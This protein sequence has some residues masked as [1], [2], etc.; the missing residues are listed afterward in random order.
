MHSWKTVQTVCAVLLL[1]PIIHLAYL[2]SRE[3]LANLDASPLVWSAEMEAYARADQLS[4]RLEK[5]L[6]VV[7]GQRVKLWRD[8][9]DLLAPKPVLMRG[10]GNATI[11]DIIYHYDRLI[12]F[13]GAD[14][15]VVLPATSEFH[16]RDM[17]SADEFVDAIQTLEEMDAKLNATRHLYIFTPLKTPLYPQDNNKIDQATLMLKTWAENNA[18][19]TILD[20][21]NLLSDS[22]GRA[23]PNYYRNDGVNLNEH[24]YL[25]LSIMLQG[26]VE[27]DTAI[28]GSTTDS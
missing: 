5:P 18:R 11:D 6:V 24:G 21:N 9:E 17:K 7:G 8:L 20:A 10:L 4:T 16:I 27:R 15:L 26:Q 2:V 13:Y 25:R 12:G 3:A 14:T 22:I 28:A 1:V 19:I 23:K